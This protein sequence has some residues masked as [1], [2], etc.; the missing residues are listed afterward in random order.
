MSYVSVIITTYNRT[1]LLIRA[2]RSVLAQE[3]RNFELIIIDDCSKEDV[4]A[5]LLSEF[6]TEL[7]IEQVRFV[8]NE[9]NMERSHCRNKGIA[10]AKGDYIA[11]LDDDDFWLVNHLADAVKIFEEFEQVALSFGGLVNFFDNGTVTYP[12]ANINRGS[13][14]LYREMCLTGRLGSS[15]AA[16]FKKEVFDFVGQYDEDLSIYEDRDLFSRIAMNYG[17]AFTGFPSVVAYTH[18]GTYSYRGLD[19][20]KAKVKERVCLEILKNDKKYSFGMSPNTRREL[21]LNLTFQFPLN[22]KQARRYLYEA[23]KL[24]FRL[25]FSFAIWKHFV[26]LHI[27]KSYE[28]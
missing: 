1:E 9:R 5:K 18:E 15:I 7:E 22:S 26:A 14:M 23:V 8:K 21:Y 13:G 19:L 11:F 10:L 6:E 27:R 2:V 12:N 25:L 24:D 16:V 3:Y 4:Y 28:V 17:V 20:E